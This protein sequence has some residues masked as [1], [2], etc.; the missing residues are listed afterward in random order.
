MVMGFYFQILLYD[1]GL[2]YMYIKY[3]GRAKGNQAG[4]IISIQAEIK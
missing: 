4:R 2:G 1:N 3:H